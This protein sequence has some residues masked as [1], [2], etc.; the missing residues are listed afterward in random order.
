MARLNIMQKIVA[1]KGVQSNR[2]GKSRV[3]KEKDID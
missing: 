1:Q 2:F 3:E